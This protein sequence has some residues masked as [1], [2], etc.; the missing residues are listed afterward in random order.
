MHAYTRVRTM[1]Q[2]GAECTYTPH[3]PINS[4][5]SIKAR[6]DFFFFLIIFIHS[7]LFHH[8]RDR[9]YE[10]RPG[11][12]D[13]M[14]GDLYYT[15]LLYMLH[16]LDNVPIVIINTPT[17][18]SIVRLQPTAIFTLQHFRQLTIGSVLVPHGLH[19]SSL[20]W[21]KVSITRTTQS[22]QHSRNMLP[23]SITY[24]SL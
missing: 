2:P 7:L 14:R 24:S 11:V 18:T 9:S 23:R 5:F 21:R 16:S 17:Y 13:L 12:Q 22:A 3:A 19:A 6:S 15:I 8:Y 4:R 20:T 1:D 10:R